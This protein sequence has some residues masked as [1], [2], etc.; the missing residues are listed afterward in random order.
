MKV[1]P[2][3]GQAWLP[4]Q[5]LSG[6]GAY[7]LPRKRVVPAGYDESGQVKTSFGKYPIGYDPVTGTATAMTTS[8][9]DFPAEGAA[10]VEDENVFMLTIHPVY[11]QVRHACCIA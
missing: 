3:I 9:Y 10:L 4:I 6:S 11:G 7:A 8:G 5:P 1:F 2:P